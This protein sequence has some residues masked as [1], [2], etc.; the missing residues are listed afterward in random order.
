MAVPAAAAPAPAAPRPGLDLEVLDLGRLG[1]LEGVAIQ[2]R[3]VLALQAGAGRP[4]LYLLEHPPVLTLGRN[5]RDAHVLAPPAEL[6]RLGVE[7]HEASRGGDVTFHGPG[8]LVGY[9]VMALPEGRRGVHAYVRDVEEALIR[10]LAEAGIE[11]A[12]DPGYPGVW[13][14][15]EKVAALGVRIARWVTSHGFALNV[16][17]DL[18]WYR[19]ITPCGLVGRGVTSIAALCAAAGRPAPSM[20]EVKDSVA[21][22]FRAVFAG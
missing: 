7:V 22:H 13:V 15:G 9:P 5:A 11:G 21:R 1:Y 3:K 10:V 6:G 19:L 14:N 4:V 20:A 8:Q 12:R 2:E 17:P 18:S 16:D